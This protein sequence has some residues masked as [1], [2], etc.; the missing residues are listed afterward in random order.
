MLLLLSTALATDLRDATGLYARGPEDCATREDAP[1]VCWRGSVERARIVEPVED[2]WPTRP[3]RV[4]R[5]APDSTCALGA[6]GRVRC[7][8]RD[9][10]RLFGMAPGTPTDVPV[11]VPDLAGIR[12]L[13]GRC[14]LRDGTV[15]CATERGPAPHDVLG[16]LLADA[17]DAAVP[18]VDGRAGLLRRQDGTVMQWGDG[19]RREVPIPPLRTASPSLLARADHACALLP[20]GRVGCW[21]NGT[22]PRVDDRTGAPVFRDRPDPEVADDLPCALR[23]GRVTCEARPG[24]PAVDVPADRLDVH[25]RHGCALAGDAVACF[26]VDPGGWILVPERTGLT[27][28]LELVVGPRTAVRT[29]S[30]V[31]E[32]VEGRWAEVLPPGPLLAHGDVLCAGLACST[33]QGPSGLPPDEATAC[34]ADGCLTASPRV[35]GEVWL[36]ETAW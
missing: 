6:D 28:V 11:E 16:P 34:T 18:A 14:G 21:G 24:R 9:W 15:I 12:V 19:R 26:G 7:I 25:G 23:D 17:L 22:P 4:V 5:V 3:V 30:A 27:G 29:E 33:P 32:L 8:G 10:R 36:V 13:L 31:L 1:D 35:H 20:G 2:V